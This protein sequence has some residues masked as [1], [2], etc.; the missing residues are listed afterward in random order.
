LALAKWVSIRGMKEWLI[1]PP[2]QQLTVLLGYPMA[3][4]L[5][6]KI[7][8]SDTLIIHDAN[9]KAA[10]DLARNVGIAMTATIKIAD[11]PKELATMSVSS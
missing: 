9:P 3:R 1:G 4:N 11:T 7:P 6:A 10:K 8:P 5:R 2:S